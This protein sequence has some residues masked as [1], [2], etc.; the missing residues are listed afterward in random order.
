MGPVTGNIE[1]ASEIDRV[2]A[3]FEQGRKT[4]SRKTP[5]PDEL[6][7]MAI[8]TAR[9]EGVNRTAQQLHLDAGKLNGFCW[10]PTLGNARDAD[11][12]DS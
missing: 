4:R 3:R 2:R 7:S 10:L 5:I 9:R 12:T 1:E 6:W 11:E 8:D